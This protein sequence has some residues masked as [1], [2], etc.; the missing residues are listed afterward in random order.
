M[1]RK[2]KGQVIVKVLQGETIQDSKEGGENKNTEQKEEEKKSAL[3]DAFAVSLGLKDEPKIESLLDTVDFNGIVKYIKDGKAK[4][5]I[6]MAGAGISTSA[7]IP[8]F[9][10]PETGLYDNLQKYNLPEPTAVFSID[11]FKVSRILF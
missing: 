7:G 2:K 1:I 6:T 3:F 5:I 11:Y 10:S 8:D 9:R 4:N